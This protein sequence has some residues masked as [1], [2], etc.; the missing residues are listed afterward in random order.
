M[1]EPPTRVEGFS[2]GVFARAFRA[3]SQE[4]D[5]SLARVPRAPLRM[6][7]WGAPFEKGRVGGRLG[8]MRRR[9]MRKPPSLS[10]SFLTRASEPVILSAAG[11]KDLLWVLGQVLPG[12]VTFFDQTDLPRS[13]PALDR[14]L[15]GNGV[16]NVGK[17]LEVDEAG[18]AVP[19]G[20]P[21]LPPRLCSFTR[22][23]RSFVTPVYN[24]RE[25]LAMM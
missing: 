8:Y 18:D 2:D 1:T 7:C 3:P 20:E 12:R 11:A 6:T 19:A 16:A 22:R 24:T 13:L 25:R 4:A 5:P 10:S 9:R 23:V 21:A 15:A 14:L 17:L